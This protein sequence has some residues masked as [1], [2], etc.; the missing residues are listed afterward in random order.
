VD[1]TD[2]QLLAMTGV[3]NSIA[4]LNLR[5]LSKVALEDTGTIN[6]EEL[7]A[8]PLKRYL[9]DKYGYGEGPDALIEPVKKQA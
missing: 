5:R 2:L 4:D 8:G 3:R 7:R 9:Y 6:V 1:P